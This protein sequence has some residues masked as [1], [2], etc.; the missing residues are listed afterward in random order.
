MKPGW[1][2]LAVVVVLLVPVALTV[3]R[4]A[5]RRHKESTSPLAQH[6]R[7]G[8]KGG[9]DSLLF[10]HHSCGE[11]W[12]NDGLLE[13]LLAKDYLADYNDVTYGTVISPDRDRPASLGEVPGD[14]TDMEHWILWFNDYLGSLKVYSHTG[15]TAVNRIIMFKSC[16]PN[17]H[18]VGRGEEPGDPFSSEKTLANYKAL[19]RHPDGPGKTYERDGVSYRPLE[20]VFGTN[21]DVLFVPVTAPPLAF[22]HTDPE[23]ARLAREFNR[24]LTEEWLPAYNAARPGVDNVAVFDWFDVLAHEDTDPKH[25]NQLR[26][27]YGG[28][29]DNSHPKTNANRRS[30]ELFASGP[31]A[32]LDKAW[33]TFRE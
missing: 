21:P 3:G 23:A 15:H 18:L 6:T 28:A 5:Y 13:A 27:E 20:D 1:I 19:Y 11:N 12:L 32:F 31:D 2:A 14:L 33:K 17:S 7:A 22:S 24:W 9:G 30:V 8:G 4:K 10:I 29:T 25:P 26:A 16:Y